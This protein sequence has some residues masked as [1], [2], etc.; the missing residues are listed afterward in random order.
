MEEPPAG[1]GHL[2]GVEHPAQAVGVGDDV[3]KGE[4]VDQKARH[5]AGQKGGPLG[6]GDPLAQ[7]GEDTVKG[8]KPPPL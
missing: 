3:G 7:A 1:H 5:K 4:Q 2:L 8:H 6:G